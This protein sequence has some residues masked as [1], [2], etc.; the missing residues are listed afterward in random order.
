[1]KNENEKARAVRG[2][3]VD[4]VCTA[5]RKSADSYMYEI[6]RSSGYVAQAVEDMTRE[7]QKELWI[8]RYHAAK[9]RL[10]KAANI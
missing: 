3:L 7:E 10:L 6:A 9:R 4:A 2:R 8:E 1:M 5:A